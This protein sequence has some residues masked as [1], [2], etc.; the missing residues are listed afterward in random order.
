MKWGLALSGGALRGA[1]HIGVLS[2]LEKNDLRPDFIAGTSSGSLVAALYALG[3]SSRQMTELLQSLSASKLYDLN[4]SWSTLWDA[5]INLL[6]WLIKAP[7]RAYRPLPSGLLKGDKVLQWIEEI[8]GQR[9]F[10]DTQIPLAVMATDINTGEAVCYHTPGYGPNTAK[11]GKPL[12]L[13]EDVSLSM[14][15]RASIAIPGIF[16]PVQIDGRTLVDGGVV[17][18]LPS[19]VLRAMGATRVVAVNL[20]YAG[21]QKE[22]LDNAFE[23]AGQALDIMAREITRFRGIKAADYCLNPHIYD[24]GLTDF[25]KILD[26]VRRG[27]QAAER[28]LPDLQALLN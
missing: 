9:R 26:C 23:I 18:N 8:T 12:L 27:R 3:L 5:G 19:Q 15:L 24:V 17:D 13:R 21:Q 2:V 28:A 1:A 11:L 4:L 10:Y 14:A 16:T 20:G 25:D 6:L 22:G 7:A